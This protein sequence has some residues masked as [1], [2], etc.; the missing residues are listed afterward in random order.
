M[1]YKMSDLA[2]FF[3]LIFAC[4]EGFEDKLFVVNKDINC[5]CF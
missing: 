1:N 4:D 2:F 5:Y 3:L